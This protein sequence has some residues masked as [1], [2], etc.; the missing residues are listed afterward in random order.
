MI[1]Q[2]T[3]TNFICIKLNTIHEYIDW[4]NSRVNANI[5]KTNNWQKSV[6][7]LCKYLNSNNFTHNVI[8]RES[9]DNYI[10]VNI[11]VNVLFDTFE[12]EELFDNIKQ[13]REE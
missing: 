3:R 12:D 11:H 2:I 8:N 5:N 6:S 9:I 1:L 10:D 4:L 13:F 7:N